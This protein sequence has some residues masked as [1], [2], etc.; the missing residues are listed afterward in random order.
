MLEDQ[1]QKV[2]ATPASK[3]ATKKA[4]KEDSVVIDDIGDEPINLDDIPF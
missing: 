1:I 2:Q 4:A 3:P